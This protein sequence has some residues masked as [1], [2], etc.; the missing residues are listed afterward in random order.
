[1]PCPAT[2][3]LDY[4]I[5]RCGLCQPW[6][7]PCVNYIYIWKGGE[8]AN[9]T[10]RELSRNN[11][12]TVSGPMIQYRTLS[13]HYSRIRASPAFF[14]Q[15]TVSGGICHQLRSRQILISPKL[16]HQDKEK[17]HVF[18]PIAVAKQIRGVKPVAASTFASTPCSRVLNLP[19]KP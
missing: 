18:T 10:V 11:E 12:T 13:E 5:Y 7:V 14:Y 9:H 1:M 17:L 19:L 15:L 2:I 8:E 4:A 3:G 16:G 6:V